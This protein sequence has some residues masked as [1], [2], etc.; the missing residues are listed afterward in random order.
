MGFWHISLD[1]VKREYPKVNEVFIRLGEISRNLNYISGTLLN[2]VPVQSRTTHEFI[3]YQ[4]AENKIDRA[5]RN[6]RVFP[7]ESVELQR[8]RTAH[9][10]D[11]EH[12]V[13][14][15]GPYADELARSLNAL[16]IAIA[17]DI[18]FRNGAYRPESEEGRKTLA[19]ELTHAAQYEGKKITANST[20]KELEEEAEEAEQKEGYNPDP[21]V[22]INI[23]GRR[24][25][26]PKSKMNYYAEKAADKIIK[27]VED[28]K[29]SLDE[30]G[31]LGLLCAFDEW[32]GGRQYG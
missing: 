13:L 26:F 11:L 14:H 20:R 17:G 10:D 19:H 32:I 25:S 8:F 28:Q 9:N 3:D 31:Y 15:T 4:L 30:R 21:F 1:R 18:Y 5:T 29:Y 16:A 22:V 27:W 24:Y 23:N 6:D 12:A 2:P 7:L